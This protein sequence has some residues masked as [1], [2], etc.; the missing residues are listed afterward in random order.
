MSKYSLIFYF[1]GFLFLCACSTTS[2]TSRA[3]VGKKANRLI[4]ETYLKE[5]SSY[6]YLLA[7]LSALNGNSN[8][9][10]LHIKSAQLYDNKNLFLKVR[11]VKLLLEQN[12]LYKGLDKLDTLLKVHLN[13]PILLELKAQV[14]EILKSY[15]SAEKIY[16]IMPK[17]DVVLLAQIRL[18]FLQKHFR[19]VIAL[20]KRVRFQ[21]D[22]FLSETR[23][24]LGKAFEA[25]GQWK[26]AKKV[27]ENSLSSQINVELFLLFAFADLY[28]KQKKV[29]KELQLLLKYKEYV[30]ESY[31]VEQ[32]LFSIYVEREENIKA[33]VH[34]ESLLEE[35]VKDLSFQFQVSLLFVATKQYEKA[36][37]LLEQIIAVDSKLDR[38][39][40]YLG[41]MYSQTK[42]IAKAKKAFANIVVQSAYYEEAIRANYYFLYQ[43]KKWLLAEQL[44]K[45]AIAPKAINIKA[46]KNLGYFLVL[47]YEDRKQFS[48]ALSYAQDMINIFPNFVNA[49]NYV[50]YKWITSGLHLKEAEILATKAHKL[51]PNNPF[52]MDTLGWLFFKKGEYKQAKNYL[53]LAYSKDRSLDVIEHLGDLYK[54]FNKLAKANRFYTQAL[55]LAEVPE[56]KKRLKNKLS[57]LSVTKAKQDNAP[58]KKLQPATESRQPSSLIVK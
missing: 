11:E 18:A 42:Q 33:L 32:R 17:S 29:N 28:K 56:D 8:Q 44:L 12:N 2:W 24:Y 13:E 16:K 54:H 27:Y 51:E 3:V 48:K 25:Q 31:L 6:H 7:E 35:G 39:Q 38:I 14:Y 26:Q 36:I 9:S 5:Q 21:Q 37:V 47:H 10:A 52:V 22:T 1:L 49:I 58:S 34:A 53:E 45:N 30:A 41:L 20:A 19:K 15:K 55:R 40:F 4:D 23:Y 57:L 50:A 46:K 43:E